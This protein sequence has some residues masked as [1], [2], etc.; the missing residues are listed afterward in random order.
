MYQPVK[1]VVRNV[2]IHFYDIIVPNNESWNFSE[3]KEYYLYLK[4][5]VPTMK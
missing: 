1:H 3:D 5:I 2:N 4:I